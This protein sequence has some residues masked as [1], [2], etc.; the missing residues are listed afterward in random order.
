[1]VT[2]EHQV[3]QVYQVQVVHQV[4]AELKVTKVNLEMVQVVH[5]V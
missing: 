3:L 4:K 5:L 1:M 2:M